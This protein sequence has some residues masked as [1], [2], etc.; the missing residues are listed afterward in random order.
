MKILMIKSNLSVFS[1]I[2][3]MSNGTFYFYVTLTPKK[4]NRNYSAISNSGSQRWNV[5]DGHGNQ[6]RD[7]V[8]K[9]KR[10]S[11]QQNR[12]TLSMAAI[13][14]KELHKIINTNKS[15]LN[16][17]MPHRIWIMSRDGL[18]KNDL[19]CPIFSPGRITQEQFW[20]FLEDSKCRRKY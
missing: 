14:E 10:K 17:L 5:Q 9:Q 13:S 18:K 6:M 11:E 12:E 1:V 16:H 20:V 8:I 15:I 2:L 7:E 4:I 3:T 19:P